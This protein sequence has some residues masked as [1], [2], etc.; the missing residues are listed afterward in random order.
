MC[1]HFK[2]AAY[3]RCLN[4]LQTFD[5]L[6]F[7]QSEKGKGFIVYEKNFS[8]QK[9]KIKNRF[10]FISE[11]TEKQQYITYEYMCMNNMSRFETNYIY[12]I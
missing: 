8:R 1:V 10:V 4:C 7:S 12:V 11:N 9:L 2:F 6:T 5:H 3:F